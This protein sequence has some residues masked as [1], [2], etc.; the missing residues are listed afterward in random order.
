M[1]LILVVSCFYSFTVI[2]WNTLYL[3]LLLQ[4][5]FIKSV[6]VYQYLLYGITQGPRA[7][8]LG[9]YF[10]KILKYL[11]NHSCISN[12][13][14]LVYWLNKNTEQVNR[15]IKEKKEKQNC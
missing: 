15:K 11:F 6:F 9:F 2:K 1:S 8:N 14:G 7:T 13:D 10:I 4:P 5:W 12:F 3:R